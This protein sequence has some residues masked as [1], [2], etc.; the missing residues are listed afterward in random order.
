MGK[1]AA[2]YLWKDKFY[3]N[4]SMC[5]NSLYGRNLLKEQKIVAN[6]G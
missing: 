6:S 2:V 4:L 5:G 1:E 3:Q